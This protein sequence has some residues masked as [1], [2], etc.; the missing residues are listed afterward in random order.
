MG[1]VHSQPMY[2]S[3]EQS[4]P[5]T[6]I[7]LLL[8]PC[9]LLVR[10]LSWRNGKDVHRPSEITVTSARVSTLK[11]TS[12]PSTRMV[13]FHMVAWF[14]L[15]HRWCS[16]R[17]CCS[18]LLH[19]APWLCQKPNCGSTLRYSAPSYCRCGIQRHR[20]NTVD[21][22]GFTATTRALSLGW[23]WLPCSC[24]WCR[25]CD[26]FP[27]NWDILCRESWTTHDA[28]VTP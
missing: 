7:G 21:K 27:S 19:Q 26:P 3:V 14:A 17:Y 12:R 25:L 22:H 5:V 18:G 2:C 11:G 28:C 4:S 15:M 23:L 1:W 16:D 6:Y 10:G 20:L 24:W 8:G 13:Q 9:S